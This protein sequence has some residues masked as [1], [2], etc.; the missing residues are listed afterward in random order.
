MRITI[1]GVISPNTG[2]SRRNRREKRR[3]GQWVAN[4]EKREEA[5][6]LAVVQAWERRQWVTYRVAVPSV[7]VVAGDGL[8]GAMGEG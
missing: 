7:A 3:L 5:R 4:R 1:V 8:A 2:W 6:L